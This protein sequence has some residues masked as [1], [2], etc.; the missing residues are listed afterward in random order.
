MSLVA[1]LLAS[2]PENQ[3]DLR[4]T[5]AMLASGSQELNRVEGAYLAAQ[6]KPAS[7]RTAAE[8]SR[9]IG[10]VVHAHIARSDQV[11]GIVVAHG[12]DVHFDVPA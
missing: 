5:K 1:G 2:S 6:L 9:D 11:G 12:L 7:Q 8:L 4:G 10:A 3:V